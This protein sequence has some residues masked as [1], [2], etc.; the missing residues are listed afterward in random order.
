M[1]I[2]RPTPRQPRPE[3]AELVFQ[4]IIFSVYHWQQKMFDGSTAKFEQLSRNDA[5][6]VIPVTSNG[7][8]LV[9]KQRQ[10]GRKTYLAFPGGHLEENETPLESAKR[11][12]AEETGYCARKWRLFQS[13][14][15]TSK[16][17]WAVYYFIAY[18]CKK[19]SKVK[20]DAGE[21]VVV[22][23]LKFQEFLKC[24]LSK[25]FAEREFK[26]QVYEALIDKRKMLKLKQLLF[27][28]VK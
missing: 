12:L 16:A 8:I 10:P 17:D 23:K 25:N 5:V 13:L 15:P 6:F 21:Q 20:C 26:M 24:C 27:K 19:V 28:Y 7:E 1:T 9:T 11:E 4:G 2:S 3:D 22:K 18:D 14:Q